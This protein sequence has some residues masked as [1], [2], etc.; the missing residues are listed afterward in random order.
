MCACALRA[1]CAAALL[2][3]G[4]CVCVCGASVGFKLCAILWCV[5]NGPGR[6]EFSEVERRSAEG[7]RWLRARMS[8]ACRQRDVTDTKLT[9]TGRS[10]LFNTLT[11]ACGSIL[12]RSDARPVTTHSSTFAKRLT[13]SPNHTQASPQRSSPSRDDALRFSQQAATD[14]VAS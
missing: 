10:V 13:Q 11:K 2:G 3:A 7:Y 5:S 12:T 9:P 4:V 6:R 8:S 1:G 14:S